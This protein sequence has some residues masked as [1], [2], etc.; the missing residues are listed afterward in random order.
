MASQCMQV[1]YKWESFKGSACRAGLVEAGWVRIRNGTQ[2]SEFQHTSTDDLWSG[3][4]GRWPACSLASTS[5][6]GL[7]LGIQP[8]SPSGER[9]ARLTPAYAPS[10][11]RILRGAAR[12]WAMQWV[13]GNGAMLQLPPVSTD[14]DK[15]DGPF[16]RW[17]GGRV[18]KW[19]SGQKWLGLLL[20]CP[21]R[22][23]LP[24]QRLAGQVVEM[25]KWRFDLVTYVSAR[26]W[27]GV[28]ASYVWRRCGEASHSVLRSSSPV[29]V[30]G[31]VRSTKSVSG[32]T[33]PAARPIM[34]GVV[35]TY[36]NYTT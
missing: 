10:S 4:V 33:A 21:Y 28:G 24:L 7:S 29:F 6:S 35:G 25:V 27:Q 8:S 1:Q 3:H 2:C 15:I 14:G 11:I 18:G 5:L 32:M 22:P 34:Y 36:S 19:A 20:S 12:Q 30:I 17:V 9:S 23:R 13:M 26:L 31:C 16:L